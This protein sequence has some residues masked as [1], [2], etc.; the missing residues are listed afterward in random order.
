M[1]FCV[2]LFQSTGGGV[3][4]LFVGTMENISNA[5]LLLDYQMNHLKVS[6]SISQSGISKIIVSVA[7]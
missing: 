4:F 2:G 1:C 3:Q 6:L 7:P 5:K